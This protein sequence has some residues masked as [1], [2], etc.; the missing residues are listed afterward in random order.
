MSRPNFGPA[1]RVKSGFRF[2]KICNFTCRNI[3]LTRFFSITMRV[4]FE[5]LFTN[6]RVWFKSS[7][8]LTKKCTRQK[9]MYD[10]IPS[11]G[12]LR[13]TWKVVF[14][15]CVMTTIETLKISLLHVDCINTLAKRGVKKVTTT[16]VGCPHKVSEEWLRILPWTTRFSLF[17]GL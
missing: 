15:F 2:T 14:Q 7:L 4:C 3:E 9:K 11:R 6:T 10:C 13:G 17:D 1:P 8:K 16:A 12:V 5:T